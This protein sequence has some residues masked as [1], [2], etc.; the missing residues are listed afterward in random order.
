MK[1]GVEYIKIDDVKLQVKPA[2]IK[3]RY[4][5]LFNGQKALEDVGNEYINQNID[6]I[7]GDII[8]Q[9]EQ[10][11]ERRILKVAN[12]VFEKASAAEFFP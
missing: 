5:N 11:M 12:Q 10:G 6:L 8:P 2:S 1:N 4:E 7:S 9:V 3:V